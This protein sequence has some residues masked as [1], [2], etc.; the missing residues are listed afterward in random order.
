MPNQIHGGDRDP[1][2][3]GALATTIRVSLTEAPEKKSGV[4]Q[5]FAGSGLR[6]T[7][8]ELRRCPPVVAPI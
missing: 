4:L 6:K 2:G 7:M 8:V 5:H 3:P 1:A